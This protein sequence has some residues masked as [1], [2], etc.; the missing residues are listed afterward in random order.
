[1]TRVNLPISEIDIPW[2]LCHQSTMSH[3]ISNSEMEVA[4][5]SLPGW[6]VEDDT[7]VKRFSLASY[8]EAIAKVVRISFEAEDSNHHPVITLSY[9]SLEVK[10]TTNDMG[11][12]ITDKDLK[13]A[14][15]IEEI[16]SS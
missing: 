4:L 3:L 11:D 10:L 15:K 12:K 6:S 1:M 14:A 16:V 9:T 5:S 8:R 2:Q 7:L 13:M